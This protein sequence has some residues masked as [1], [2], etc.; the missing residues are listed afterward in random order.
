MSWVTVD[1][2]RQS[3]ELADL[4]ESTLSLMLSA[5]MGSVEREIGYAVES[6]SEEETYDGDGR[7]IMLLRRHPVSSITQVVLVNTDDTEDAY[8]GSDFKFNADTGELRWSSAGEGL[9]YFP[10]G[11][12]NVKVTYVAGHDPAPH[13]LQHAV[14]MIV[15]EMLKHEKGDFRV[16]S[17][18]MGDYAVSFQDAEFVTRMAA[19]PAAAR[20]IV[21]RYKDRVSL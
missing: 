9:G 2:A 19:W 4:D 5:A 21:N 18:K 13:D 10:R 16:K 17:E 11:F 3:E 6:S 12:R 14:V 15:I 1:R 7:G 20:S 8:V